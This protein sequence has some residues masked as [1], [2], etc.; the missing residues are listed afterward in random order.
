MNFDDFIDRMLNTGIIIFFGIFGAAIGSIVTIQ[1]Y[2]QPELSYPQ[3]LNTILSFYPNITTTCPQPTC[4]QPICPVV[5]DC[6]CHNTKIEVDGCYN[7]FENILYG[8]SKQ[9]TYELDVYDCTEFAKYGTERLNTL[10]WRAQIY[11]VDANCLIF[12]KKAC[13]EEIT[14]R[15]TIIK[16]YEVYVEAQTGEIIHPDLYELYGIK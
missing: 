4:P 6:D 13:K 15:H 11:N 12:G 1:V 3:C 5:P 14:I 10:G 2:E 16:V 7:T 8:M 9:K